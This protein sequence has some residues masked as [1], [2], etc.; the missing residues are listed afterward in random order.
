MSG[1]KTREREIDDKKRDKGRERK[2]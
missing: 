1:K 2:T